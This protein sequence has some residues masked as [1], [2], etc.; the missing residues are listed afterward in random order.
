MSE[1]PYKRKF[2]RTEIA[3][4]FNVPEC[5]MGNGKTSTF[6]NQQK[7]LLNLLALFKPVSKKNEDE[8]ERKDEMDS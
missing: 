6:R 4:V 8:K 3:K 7:I 1:I 5:I 2:K